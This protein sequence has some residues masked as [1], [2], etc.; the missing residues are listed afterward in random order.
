MYDNNSRKDRIQGGSR[1]IMGSP[2]PQGDRS[3]GTVEGNGTGNGTGQQMMR[4]GE[5]PERS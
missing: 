2:G 4:T 3:E 1:R 5:K